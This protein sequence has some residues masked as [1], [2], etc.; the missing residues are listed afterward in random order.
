MDPR[1]IFSGMLNKRDQTVY[2][3]LILHGNHTKILVRIPLKIT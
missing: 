3:L 1:V 2:L